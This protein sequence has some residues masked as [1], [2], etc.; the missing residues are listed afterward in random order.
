[1][2]ELDHPFMPK[3]YT[4]FKVNSIGSNMR[5]LRVILFYYART[6]LLFKDSKYVYLLCDFLAGGELLTLHQS[7]GR[8]D[9]HAARFYGASIVCMLEYLHHKNVV[10]RDLKLENVLLDA[11]VSE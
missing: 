6:Y 8:F 7:M 4:T 10:Y 3:L 9:G 5:T 11:Q 2:M 1:M